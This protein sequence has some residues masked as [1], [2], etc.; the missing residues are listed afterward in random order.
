S[1]TFSTRS[2]CVRSWSLGAPPA[3]VGAATALSTNA[4][5]SAGTRRRCSDL[6]DDLLDLSENVL[7]QELFEVDGR[8]DLA[9]TPVGRGA[10]VGSAGADAHVLLADQPLGLDRGDRV[11]LELDVT[12][13]AEHHPRLIVGEPDRL[14]A[15]DL[16]AGDLDGRPRLQTSHR[17]K[18]HD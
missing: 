11:L 8:L 16:D 4:S 10:L 17:R 5:R 13:D 9:E 12:L 3:A 1:S 7:R 6:I 18:L 14:D 2:I 15:T